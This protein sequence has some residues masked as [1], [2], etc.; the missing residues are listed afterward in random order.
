VSYFEGMRKE[1]LSG[2]PGL[3]LVLFGRELVG[4]AQQVE[5]VARSIAAYLIR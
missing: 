4:P 1:R 3:S 5:I 2:A